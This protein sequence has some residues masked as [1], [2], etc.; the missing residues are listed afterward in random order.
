MSQGYSF[1]HN[2]KTMPTSENKK[3]AKVSKKTSDKN[4]GPKLSKYFNK[5]NPNHKSVNYNFNTYNDDERGHEKVDDILKSKNK[6]TKTNG[7]YTSP[8]EKEENICSTSGVFD[9][10]KSHGEPMDESPK[11][12]YSKV[13]FENFK[14][15][16]KGILAKEIRNQPQKYT[17]LFLIT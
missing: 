11:T 14:K 10:I 7:T 17:K 4:D 8:L 2:I 9:I 15:T 5:K 12:R 16:R 1:P 13:N 3:D 6:F